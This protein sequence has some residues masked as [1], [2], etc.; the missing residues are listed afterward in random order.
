[1]TRSRDWVVA[2]ACAV[3]AFSIPFLIIT[4]LAERH[5]EIRL[6]Q[7]GDGISALIVDGRARVLVVNSNDRTHTRAALGRLARPWEPDFSTVIST[8]EDD[9]AP[10]L[11]EAL[12]YPAL[13]RVVIAGLPG[14]DPVWSWIETEA[15]K[16]EIEVHFAGEPISLSSENL[17]IE[18]QPGTTPEMAYVSVTQGNVVVLVGLGALPPQIPAQ[19]LVTHYGPGDIEQYPL[20]VMPASTASSLTPGTVLMG[21]NSVVTLVLEEE[22]LRV[23]GGRYIPA[24]AAVN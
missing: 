4:A 11:W 12:E 9:A 6:V 2:G 5:P 7:T 10:G 17:Q 20:T 18:V 14:S 13:R 15:R 21:E 22:Q 8:A 3:I 19:T 1:M 16:R 23:R 24:D